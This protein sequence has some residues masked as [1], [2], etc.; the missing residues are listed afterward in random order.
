[1]GRAVV[2]TERQAMERIWGDNPAVQRE[3]T[4]APKLPAYQEVLGRRIPP[5]T[6]EPDDPYDVQKG[7]LTNPTVHIGLNQLKR[8]VNALIA[9]PGKPEQS[10]VELARALK[11]NEEQ[12]AAVNREIVRNTRAAEAR[13]EKL[14]EIGVDDNGYNRVLLKLWEELNLSQPESRECIYCGT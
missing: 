9:R 7:R 10:A 1:S 11:L 6:G 14:R 8:V 2:L 4:N 13:S 5:G 3:V 12:K